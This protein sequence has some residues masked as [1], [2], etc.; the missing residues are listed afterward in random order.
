MV[1]ANGLLIFV[2]GI[3]LLVAL[4]AWA[5]LHFGSRW[6][7]RK[8]KLTASQVASQLETMFIFTGAYRVLILN[9]ALV[10][11][12]PVLAWVLTNSWIVVGVCVVAAF[13]IPRKVIRFL[14]WKRLRHIEQQLPDTIL[15][16]V[17]A[18]RAG[19]SLSIALES[20]AKEGKPPLSQEIELLLREIRVGVDFSVALRN[21]ERRVPLQDMTMVAAGMALSREVG[22][23]LAE[24]LDSIGKTIRARL[25]ME[26]KIR[27]LTAQGKMQGYVMA[28][29]P[30]F[31]IIILRFM[32][33][34]A[35]APMF[36]TWYGWVTVGVIAVTIAIGHHFIA[37]ITNIDI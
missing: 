4:I 31:L 27:S 11:L 16:V 17:G 36:T 2:V 23:N 25:Q 9:T 13:F 34:E 29:L 26:G 12:L 3:F 1:N 6:L 15:M 24:T 21:L 10:T 28:G 18:L 32:E 19:A 22:A 35:M 33:P 30:I 5:T 7:A 20:A 8:Q 37:K 14:T